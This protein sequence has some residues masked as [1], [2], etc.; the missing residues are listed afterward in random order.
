MSPVPL[1]ALKDLLLSHDLCCGQWA[2]G[3]YLLDNVLD[4]LPTNTQIPQ[5]LL[6][7][8]LTWALALSSNQ[9]G[10]ALALRSLQSG[11]D[12][13]LQLPA[14]SNSI[15]TPYYTFPAVALHRQLTARNSP[16]QLSPALPFHGAYLA[17]HP[18]AGT[19]HTLPW[20]CW[21]SPRLHLGAFIFFL[22]TFL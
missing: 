14:A 18:F 10:S 1:G 16:S 3:Y 2:W 20:E 6:C 9:D 5:P 12:S 4:F 13:G 7:S 11:G 8:Q 17:H 22:H 21:G 15:L 19:S